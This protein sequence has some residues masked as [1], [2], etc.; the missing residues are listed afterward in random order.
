MVVLYN[1]QMNVLIRQLGGDKSVASYCGS[2]SYERSSHQKYILEAY[3][4][5]VN[6]VE[7]GRGPFNR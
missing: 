7:A 1:V 3:R 6:E 5:P 2:R 4:S